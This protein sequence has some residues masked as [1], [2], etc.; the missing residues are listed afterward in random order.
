MFAAAFIA[1]AA[2]MAA[3]NT[4]NMIDLQQVQRRIV[5]D[6]DQRRNL[7]LIR[8]LNSEDL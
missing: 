8:R 7:R 6:F 2:F 5:V 4:Q 1:A 3:G